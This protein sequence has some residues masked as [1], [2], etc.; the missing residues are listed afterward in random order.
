MTVKW[1]FQYW[2]GSAWATL[3]NATLDHILEEL[4]GTEETMFNLPNTAANRAIIT[5]NVSVDVFYN[6]T[7]IFP[8]LLTGAKY[9]AANLQC[10]VYN[11]VFVNLKQ[12]ITTLTKAYSSVAANTILAD[13]VALT[14]GVSV[15]S[16]PTTLIS[17]KFTNANA[18]DAMAALAKA[19]GLYYWGASGAINIGTRDATTYTPTVFEMGTSRGIDRSKQYGIVIVKGVDI[20]GVQIRVAQVVAAPSRFSL[21]RKLLI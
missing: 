10:Y 17:I 13:I 4:N 7:L 8:G 2:T 14:S 5:S 1:I 16:C 18:F 9:T 12:G 19:L 20:N 3:E 6:G 15:G 21:T 11:P